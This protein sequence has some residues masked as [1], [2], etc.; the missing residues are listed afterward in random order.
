MKTIKYSIPINGGSRDNVDLA[1][2]RTFN[3]ILYQIQDLVFIGEFTRA[4]IRNIS[5]SENAVFIECD[6]Y[7]YNDGVA[8]NELH[9]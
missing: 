4:K 2:R 3:D 7:S 9:A 5:Y 6:I 8:Q 1:L